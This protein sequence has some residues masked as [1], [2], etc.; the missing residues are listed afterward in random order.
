MVSDDI[1]TRLR[2]PCS[3]VE[4][5]HTRFGLD[6]ERAEAAEEIEALRLLGDLMRNTIVNLYEGKRLPEDVSDLLGSW[7]VARDGLGNGNLA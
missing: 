5:T 4:S 6:Q 1:V 7:D 3:W 2:E